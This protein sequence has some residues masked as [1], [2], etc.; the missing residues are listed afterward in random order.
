MTFRYWVPI[1]VL[2]L[3]D[4]YNKICQRK[5]TG[6]GYIFL[7]KEQGAALTE[8]I[9]VGHGSWALGKKGALGASP[10]ENIMITPILP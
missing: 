4:T 3:D 2:L 5:G 9:T 7:Y 6:G 10:S 1:L 8:K